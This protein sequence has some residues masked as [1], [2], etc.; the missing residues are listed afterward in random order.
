VELVAFPIGQACTTLIATLD[1]L[2]ATFSTV[3]HH[4]EQA[5]ASMGIFNPATEYTARIN[6]YNLFKSL[7]DSLTDL[8]LSRL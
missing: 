2:T 7:L 5:R 4:V 3:R 6:D 8:A 1:H